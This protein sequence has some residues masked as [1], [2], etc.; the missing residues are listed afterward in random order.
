[1]RILGL[2]VLVIG[3][4][5]QPIGWMFTQWVTIVSFVA[6]VIGV[7][8]ILSGRHAESDGG[9]GEGLLKPTGREMPGD[10][11][12]YSGQLSGGRSTSWESSHSDHGGG[13]SGDSGD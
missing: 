11:H 10:I 4:V 8:L 12:G 9:H 7:W 3:I 5:L 13:H 1:M 6:I 2:I